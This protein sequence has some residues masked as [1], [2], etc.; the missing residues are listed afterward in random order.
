MQKMIELSQDSTAA[1]TPGP[2][3]YEVNTSGCVSNEFVRKLRNDRSLEKIH[4]LKQLPIASPGA[5][6]GAAS[7]ATPKLAKAGFGSSAGRGTEPG[8]AVAQ[9]TKR[10]LAHLSI[11]SIPSRFLTPVLKFDMHEGK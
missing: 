3:A 9:H 6:Y 1:E 11:P 4:S 5:A 2:G 8:L 7:V 10:R